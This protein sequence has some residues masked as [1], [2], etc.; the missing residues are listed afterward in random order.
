MMIQHALT[1][2]GCRRIQEATAHTA[3][4]P[5]TNDVALGVVGQWGCVSF[6]GVLG[7]ILRGWWGV[8]GLLWDILGGPEAILRAFWGHLGPSWGLLGGILGQLGAILGQL[9]AI[10]GQLRPSWGHLGGPSG[11]YWA[12]LGCQLGSSRALMV[13]MMVSFAA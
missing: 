4:P 9:G 1:P 7:T 2:Q 6:W 12:H 3:D 10:L 8:W 13:V 5:S 11:P